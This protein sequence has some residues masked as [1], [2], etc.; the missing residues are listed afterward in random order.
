VGKHQNLIPFSVR[1]DPAVP[2]GADYG[3]VAIE[4]DTN[5]VDV[6]VDPGD[7]APAVKVIVSDGTRSAEAVLHFVL[8]P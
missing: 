3:P 8:Q 6:S 5:A 2:D 7:Q 4:E 1:Y